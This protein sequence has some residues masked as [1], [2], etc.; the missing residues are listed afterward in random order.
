MK[1]SIDAALLD[2]EA[3]LVYGQLC[4]AV[5]ARAHARAGDAA[6]IAGYLGG[7]KTFDV[8]V[9]DFAAGYTEVTYADHAALV[10]AVRDG[11]VDAEFGV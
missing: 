2:P 9:S 6:V 8:A 1:G 10:R 11:R 5:L 7:K 3:L 4:A